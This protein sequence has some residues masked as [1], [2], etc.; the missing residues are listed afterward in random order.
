LFVTLDDG[1]NQATVRAGAVAPIP[2]PDVQPASSK[3]SPLRSVRIPLDAFTA[4]NPAFDWN[5]IV[6][7][8]VAL[9][10]R[11]SGRIFVDDL[12]ISS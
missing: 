10:A 5:N 11:P 3:V 1:G 12:E 6:R 2:Y 8:N 4:A 9:K 7:M